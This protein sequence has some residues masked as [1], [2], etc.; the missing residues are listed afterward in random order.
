MSPAPTETPAVRPWYQRIG[1]GLITACVVIGPG[2]ILTSSN[3][4]VRNGYALSWVVVVAVIFML[5]FMSMGARL[6]VSTDRSTGTLLAERV[7]RWFAVLI[8]VSHRTF[9]R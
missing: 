9:A 4:G 5:A 3:V 2:S 8:G 7:G 1:P 6:G